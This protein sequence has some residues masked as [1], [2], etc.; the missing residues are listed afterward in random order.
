MGTFME[1]PICGWSVAISAQ[2]A[3]GWPQHRMP[4]RLA[5]TRM[6][7]VKVLVPGVP[8]PRSRVGPLS[9]PMGSPTLPFRF[10]FR[11]HSGWTV[12][13]HHF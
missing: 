12:E 2:T 1:L 5:E 6:T 8:G 3:R 10:A 9:A 4:M 7:G 11:T 13:R